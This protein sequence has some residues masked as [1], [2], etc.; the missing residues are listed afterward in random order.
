[1]NGKSSCF[2]GGTPEHHH[3]GIT[4][5]SAMMTL[6]KVL[7]AGLYF[8]KAVMLH[9]GKAVMLYFG[10]EIAVK[11]TYFIKGVKLSCKRTRVTFINIAT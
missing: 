10:K 5:P 8:G 11:A 2:Y 3:S 9:V 1:M 6:G 4:S 7:H